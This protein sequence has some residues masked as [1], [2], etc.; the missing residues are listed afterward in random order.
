MKQNGLTNKGGISRL[1]TLE[2]LILERENEILN[3]PL[4]GEVSDEEDVPEGVDLAV[5]EQKKKT[6]QKDESFETDSSDDNGSVISDESGGE[7][8]DS[9]SAEKANELKSLGDNHV[10]SGEWKEAIRC[11]SEALEHS[12]MAALYGNRSLCYMKTEEFEKA[13]RDCSCAIELDPTYKRIF[14]RRAAIRLRRR[15]YYGSAKDLQDL[16]ILSASSAVDPN[17]QEEYRIILPLA[18]YIAV[19]GNCT[20]DDKFKKLEADVLEKLGEKEEASAK[21][22]M[23]RKMW[24]Q[25]MESL[26]MAIMVS[27]QTPRLYSD[28]ALV[29][30]KLGKNKMAEK[31]CTDAID[32]DPSNPQYFRLRAEV[33]K[34]LGN[35]KGSE[36]DEKHANTLPPVA[37]K[38]QKSLPGKLNLRLEET[39]SRPSKTERP[40]P[41]ETPLESTVFI[42]IP[43]SD[44]YSSSIDE[45]YN[46]SNLPDKI[47]SLFGLP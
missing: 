41:T 15:D 18:R 14:R 34:K 22:F 13:E 35:L 8:G 37:N 40:A 21:S 45:L 6:K 38:T 1:E 17:I 12:Q 39:T 16:R 25:A 4:E 20:D 11:Y 19:Q 42:R 33:R 30:F 28:R 10:Q 7:D 26:S 29:N 23:N 2:R 46:L 27:P 3:D 36:A 44:V 43:V 9:S 32:L 31:D 5:E 47:K 24:A